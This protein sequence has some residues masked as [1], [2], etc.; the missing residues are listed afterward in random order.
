MNFRVSI[1]LAAGFFLLN[2][3]TLQA[4]CELKILKKLITFQEER[5]LLTFVE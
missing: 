2:G 5:K 1:F 3:F 4:I